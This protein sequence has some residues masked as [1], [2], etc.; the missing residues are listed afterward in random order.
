METVTIESMEDREHRRSSWPPF[1]VGSLLVAGVLIV[2]L[3][4]IQLPYLAFSA[5]PVADASDAIVAEE[6]AT[7]PPEGELLMLTV[8]NQGVNVF[9]AV[10]AG[11]DPS[12]DLV[13]RDAYR[14]PNESDEDYRNRVLAQMDDS[15]RTSIEVALG[16]LGVEMIPVDVFI[17]EVNE[18]TP[19]AEVIEVGDYITSVDGVSVTSLT[20]LSEAMEGRVPGEVIE[21]GITRAGLAETIQV[22]LVERDDGSG[23]AIIGISVYELREPPFP[24]SID[25]GV[26]GGPSAGMMHTLA[27]I[28]T[29]TEGEMTKGQIVAGTGTVRPDGTVGSIGGV[30]QKVVGAEAAGAAYMLVPEGNYEEALTADRDTIEIIPV[31]SVDEAIAFL[32]DLPDPQ[33]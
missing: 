20:E 18:G 9:E 30:R 2:A 32:E 16:H 19:A 22:E 33:Y 1:L 8:V 6:V 24:I 3:W 21:I 14:R 28:D 4:N 5:G 13:R 11:I 25:T 10:I 29:L 15:Q 26:V 27:I 31:A 12:I 23:D 7:Y 17:T